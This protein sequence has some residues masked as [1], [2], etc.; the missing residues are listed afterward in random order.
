MTN[1]LQFPEVRRAMRYQASTQVRAYW[2][3][4][5]NGRL[6]PLRSE[7]DPSG[8]EQALEY[9]FILERTGPQV[10]RF[11]LS[12]LHLAE[13]VGAEAR[14]MAV[15]DLFSHGAR[16]RV[17]EVTESMFRAP[18]IA[19]LT[20]TAVSGPGRPPLSARVTILPLQSDL[21]DISRAIGCIETEGRIGATPR[22]FEVSH[23]AT[24][25]ID[26]R[27]PACRTRSPKLGLAEDQAT[28][29][30]PAPVAQRAGHLRVVKG[31]E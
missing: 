12:G 24:T 11:R 28:F 15:T 25:A 16:A 26:A 2:E 14:G 8:I 18:E 3:A 30:A 4:L 29:L 17:A 22:Q 7:I 9:A 1:I 10:A 5:R 13:L 23:V 21:G 19:E 31:G 27:L 6:V 20:L